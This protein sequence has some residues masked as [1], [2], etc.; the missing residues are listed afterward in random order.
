MREREQQI[1]SSH[2]HDGFVMSWQ[3]RD[4]D[5]DLL[6]DLLQDITEEKSGGREGGGGEGE[7]KYAHGKALANKGR[8]KT[9]R[10]R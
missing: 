5:D 2:T 6:D 1:A 4:D 3:S 9:P 7:Y 8:Q 10:T